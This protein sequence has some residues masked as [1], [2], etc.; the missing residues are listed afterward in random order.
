MPLGSHAW[1]RGFALVTALF[2][3][4][5][6]T[7][8]ANDSPAEPAARAVAAPPVQ[9]TIYAT[10]A[11]QATATPA[12]TPSPTPEPTPDVAALTESAHYAA[13]IGDY[14]RAV[15]V[16][17]QVVAA[18]GSGTSEAALRMRLN[19]GRWQMDAGEINAAAAALSSVVADLSTAGGDSS[20]E[21]PGAHVL[22]GR[23]YAMAGDPVNAS[24]Q[25]AA[26][27]AAGS[28]ISPWLHV[29]L[30]DAHLDARRLA[31]AITHYRA[32]LDAAPNTAQE[33]ARREKLALA[34]QLSGDYQ[35]VIAQ[36]ETILSRAQ[37]PAY[38]ARILW[39]LAQAL[40]AAGQTGAAYRRMNELMANH[41]KTPQ[42]FQALQALINAGQPVDE[43]QR[44]IIGYHNG[45][46]VAAREAFRRAI[47]LYPDRANDVR[48]WAALNYLKLGSVA[49]AFRNLD[50]TIASNPAGAPATAVALGEKAKIYANAGDAANAR[51]TFERLIANVPRGQTGASVLF[52]VA[53]TFARNDALVAEATRAYEAAEAVQFDAERGPEALA[54]AAAL[55]YRLGRYAEAMTATQTL[56]SKYDRSP[57]ALL[58][59]LWLGKAQLALG[60]LVEGME[61]LQ[62]LAQQAPDA[63]EGARAAELVAD[64][65][66]PPLSAP[67]PS[68]G[69]QADEAG[70]E[71]AEAWLRGWLGLDASANVRDLREDVRSDPRFIRGSELWR[72]GFKL[73]AREEFEGLRAAFGRDALAQYQL[74]L[75]FRDIG[76]YRSSIGAAD[77]L[78]RLSPAKTPSALPA[79]I[80]KLL[81]PA[82]YGDL[83]Q[84]HAQ[85]FGLDPLLLFSLIRQES[86]FEPFAVSSAAA[87]GLMQ[88]IPSTGR[89]IYNDLNWPPN[90]T[91]ADLQKP[92]VSV[93]FGSH[94][95]AKQRRFFDGDLYAAIAAYNGGP[96]NA[97]RWKERSA[98][99][100]DVFFMAITFDETQRYVRALAANYAIYHRLYA[101]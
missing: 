67:F 8:C 63:Y 42:A 41:P 75:F 72:L 37:L 58:G 69:S 80:A 12:P 39:E 21:L 99:D 82:Y 90:Y 18:L 1:Q 33:F 10:R 51:A 78:M 19:I 54:R 95:L 88:V 7:A 83:V 29:W 53:Q 9:P 13:F 65:D 76:L 49:D 94:Y 93:R 74:A 100:P 85:E 79:F 17:R 22:L 47:V 91:T 96:G 98:G 23:A 62:A 73:E 59:R 71:E 43:L 45:S 30:G 97:L 92:Y 87:N 11:P 48:Y 89:E 14:A 3:S 66:K 6:C 26:A 32:S 5:I 31:E 64:P 28:V 40:R 52:D 44:G 35:A 50:Q 68:L 57:Q 70:Q 86:L 84:Q 20:A 2:A 81:Y 46:H 15:E 34:G 4:L 27:L 77:T 56:L 101:R 38:R 25:Y 16:G 60:D 61:T 36:Y 55:H 24:A